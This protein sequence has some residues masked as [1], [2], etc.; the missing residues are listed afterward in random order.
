MLEGDYFRV[1]QLCG[2]FNP[3]HPVLFFQ[4]YQQIYCF[5]NGKKIII[6]CFLL[7]HLSEPVLSYFY[8]S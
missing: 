4:N 8:S 1:P 7:K 5:I 3:D 6:F 2:Q